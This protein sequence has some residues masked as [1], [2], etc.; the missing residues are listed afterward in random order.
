MRVDLEILKGLIYDESYTT[1]AIPHIKEEYFHNQSLKNIFNLMYG[2]YTTY[3]K[4]P[5]IEALQVML[6][7][8]TMNETQY[9]E[10]LE[11]MTELSAKPEVLQ[12]DWLYDRTEDWAK[13]RALHNAMVQAVQIF[14][15]SREKEGANLQRTSIP[16]LFKDALSVQFKSDVG[17]AYFKDMEKQLEFYQHSEDEGNR[18]KFDI[19][20][21]NEIT[22]GGIPRKTANLVFAGVN[23]GKTAFLCYLAGMYL[24]QGL[25]VLFISCEMQETLIRERIDANVLGLPTD[26][27]YKIKEEVYIKRLKKIQEHTTG[28]LYI[29][30]YP[31][32][33]SNSITYQRLLKELALK[34]NFVPDV[35]L[36]D[37]IGI[38]ASS[39][40]PVS[41]MSNSNLYLGQVTKELRALASENNFALW[42]A[43]QL[44]R[45]GMKEVE[46]EMT[47]SGGSIDITKDVDFILSL[48][49]PEEFEEKNQMLAKQLKN[50]YNKKSR[51]RRFIIGADTDLMRFYQVDESVQGGLM[52][53]RRNKQ[54]SKQADEPAAMPPATDTKKK[55]DA[56]NWQF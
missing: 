30:E 32:I 53:N 22:R 9:N 36:I 23:V 12:S 1:K 13:D 48:S 19:E 20:I 37:Y 51:T 41:A 40:L 8:S 56:S 38:V 5:S 28:E 35:V 27:F 42:S 7:D 17:M 24:Q 34:R 4:A 50:R 16:D 15:Q 21:L 26:K 3:R 55:V 46:V 10:S 18:F 45:E 29:K 52:E 39:T 49:Q 44:N 43:H 33:R 2:H 14:E 31:P 54:K 6:E 47:H 25:N 11:F